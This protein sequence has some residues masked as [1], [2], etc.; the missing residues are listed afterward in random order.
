M[1]ARERN[2]EG[3]RIAWLFGDVI[4]GS[5]LV[6]VFGCCYVDIDVGGTCFSQFAFPIYVWICLVSTQK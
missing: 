6:S 4:F 5:G 1:G 2:V 3:R